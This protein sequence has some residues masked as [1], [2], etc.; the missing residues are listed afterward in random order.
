MEH[1]VAGDQL[2]AEQPC[3]VRAVGQMRGDPAV[4]GPQNSSSTK[5]H[6]NWEWA[7]FQKLNRR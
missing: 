4:V 5:R 3:E 1:A 6:R 2:Q 7:N